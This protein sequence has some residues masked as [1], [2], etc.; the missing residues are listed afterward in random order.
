MLDV[1]KNNAV[2]EKWGV[3][4]FTKW[5]DISATGMRLFLAVYKTGRRLVVEN[6]DKRPDAMLRLGFKQVGKGYWHSEG[7]SFQPTAIK[8]ALPEAITRRDMPISDIILDLSEVGLED[9]KDNPLTSLNDF[10]KKTSSTFLGLNRRGDEVFEGEKGVRFLVAKHRVWTEKD[11]D[12][13]VDLFLRA[14]DAVQLSGCAIG[15]VRTI[16]TMAMAD[17]A[18]PDG[19]RRTI[20]GESE[21]DC[22]AFNA[23]VTAAAI[24]LLCRDERTISQVQDRAR[25][26][27]HTLAATGLKPQADLEAITLAAHQLREKP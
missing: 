8:E 18:H 11:C 21:D 25:R 24:S 2:A 23:A 27:A 19:F 26:L 13:P 12:L 5:V 1:A 7:L 20:G 15:F 4:P 3:P 22:A 9:T 10:L 16:E 14:G 6:G 17:V